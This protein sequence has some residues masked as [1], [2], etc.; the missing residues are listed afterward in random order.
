MNPMDQG[1]FKN[2]IDCSFFCRGCLREIK[3]GIDRRKLKRDQGKMVKVVVFL[4][5]DLVLGNQGVDWK[6]AAG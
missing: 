2:S 1:F 6:N 5:G 4:I 3:A